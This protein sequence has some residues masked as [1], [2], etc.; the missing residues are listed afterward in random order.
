MVEPRNDDVKLS[1]V[2]NAKLV[3]KFDMS[4][5]VL[6]VRKP[7]RSLIEKFQIY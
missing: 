3:T 4:Y 6:Q 2:L 5:S 7:N 1:T